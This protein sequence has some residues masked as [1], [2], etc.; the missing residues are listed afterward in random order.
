MANVAQV[1]LTMFNH[2]NWNIFDE[3][4]QL[5][6]KTNDRHLID[7]IPRSTPITSRRLIVVE[8]F[9]VALFSMAFIKRRNL[10]FLKC[11]GCYLE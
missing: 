1:S 4:A 6:S 2:L 8:K 11:L 7:R 9:F 10:A 5:R 3:H